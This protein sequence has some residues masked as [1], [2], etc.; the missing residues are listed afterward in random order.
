MIKKIFCK[1][2]DE[3]KSAEWDIEVPDLK[4]KEESGLKVRYQELFFQ[5]IFLIMKNI[6]G[7]ML[8]H[9][10]I[11]GKRLNYILKD[12]KMK[13]SIATQ[14]IELMEEY[15]RVNGFLEVC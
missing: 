11:L 1:K 2:V 14:Q 10:S 8:M 6:Y 13:T 12:V 3:I 9:G 15:S 4:L 7:L 5:N